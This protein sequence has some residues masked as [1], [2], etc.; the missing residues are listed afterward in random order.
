M[1]RNP[2]VRPRTGFDPQFW[3]VVAAWAAWA[4]W[5]GFRSAGALSDDVFI[6]LR[7]AQSIAAGQGLVFNPGERV[8]GCTEPLQALVLGAARW[9]TGVS[10]P[11][12]ATVW[13]GLGVLALA[14]LVLL[15]A[16]RSGRFLSGVV[17][18]SLILGL[19]FCWSLQGFAWPWVATLLAG[20]ALLGSERLGLAGILAGL[21]VGFR[22]DAL[23]GVALLALFMGGSVS[24]RWRPSWRFL[25]AAVGT[26][27]LLALGAWLWF[28]K[29][30]PVTLAA[31]QAFAVGSERAG[32][33]SGLGFWVAAWPVFA[34]VF[35]S[36]LAPVAVL[37][38]VLGVGRLRRTS[39]PVFDILVSFGAALAIAYPILGVSFWSWYV[40]LPLIA[41][42]LSLAGYL[43]PPR[44]EDR[45]YPARLLALPALVV[46]LAAGTLGILP[47]RTPNRADSRMA[48][49]QQVGEWISHSTL[50]GVRVAAF[51]VGTIAFYADRHV[52]DLLGLVSPQHIE[53]IAAADWTGILDA[54]HADLLVLS[55]GDKINPRNRKFT[56]R[57]RWAAEFTVGKDRAAI[58][59]RKRRSVLR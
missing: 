50:P 18:G 9:V 5:A 43:V 30:L 39:D 10:L 59:V 46:L 49:Y 6:T 24:P 45:R 37:W 4:V 51:E 53:A 15:G 20:A 17:G 55:N 41:L 38:G 35:G 3:A 7:Y 22:P 28:G 36:W 32:T 34:R 33:R 31:K 29:I 14:S 19:P 47:W 52:E 16:A 11:M 27:C 12:L 48:L 8:F 21:A 25:V 1:N 13:H 2:T 54:S 44:A 58:Y 57:Y 42:G 23:L 26:V 40:I 56:A